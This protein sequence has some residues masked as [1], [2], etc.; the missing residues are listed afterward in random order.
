MCKSIHCIDVEFVDDYRGKKHKFQIK[1]SSIKRLETQWDSL[2]VKKCHI[3]SWRVQHI[4][5]LLN[6]SKT[7]EPFLPCKR[8][9]HKERKMATVRKRNIRHCAGKK[10][11]QEKGSHHF[12]KITLDINSRKASI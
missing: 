11:S 10:M 3:P 12:L 7:R 2:C 5:P 9:Y 4:W 8:P 6:N 1:C